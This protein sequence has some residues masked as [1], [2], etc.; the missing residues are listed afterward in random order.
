M[1][2]ILSYLAKFSLFILIFKSNSSA[3]HT[4]ECNGEYVFDVCWSPIHPSLFACV[5]G[6]GKL[7][8]WDLNKDTEM[9][10]AS[11]DVGNHG[12][13]ALN[14]VKWSRKGTEIAVGDDQGQISIFEVGESF[15]R[16]GADET[17]KLLSTVYGLKQLSYE[18][19][20]TDLLSYYSNS[21]R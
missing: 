1:L 2:E 15:A 4:F 5:D 12:P 17:N 3:I 6:A 14:K 18:T 13:R 10:S 19:G 11:A 21:T 8:L 20:K 7:D 9:P 16:P